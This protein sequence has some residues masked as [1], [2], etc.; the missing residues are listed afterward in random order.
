VL[1]I[2]VTAVASVVTPA[3]MVTALMLQKTAIAIA[4]IVLANSLPGDERPFII[5]LT[6]L[7]EWNKQA[8]TRSLP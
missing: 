5:S 8:I 1:V 7:D 6:L 2:A 3:V 4:A